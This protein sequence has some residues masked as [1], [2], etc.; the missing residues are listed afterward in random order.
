MA[1]EQVLVEVPY[2]LNEPTKSAIDSLQSAGLSWKLAGDVRQRSYVKSQYPFPG[3]AVAKNTTI[4]LY[5]VDG[6]TP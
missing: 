2:L 5:I 1:Q 6:P 3:V 4:D